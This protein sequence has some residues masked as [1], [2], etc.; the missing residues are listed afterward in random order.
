[1][2]PRPE[3]LAAAAWW[4]GKLAAA[5][6]HDDITSQPVTMFRW[7]RRRYSAQQVESFR[8]ALAELFEAHIA[9]PLHGWRPED[10]A[11]GR[12]FRSITTGY[13]LHPCL[14]D[15][16]E[17]AGIEV[18]SSD[19]PMETTMWIDP[20]CVRVGWG[21]GAAPVVVWRGGPGCD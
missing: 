4:A 21:R 6:E 19:L 1:M 3:A 18:D 10:P 16:A 5:E 2:T 11:W 20:G 7:P 9:E 8:A 17:A 15:A 14:L 13:G 12:G